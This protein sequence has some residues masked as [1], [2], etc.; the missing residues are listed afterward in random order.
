MHAARRTAGSRGRA[1]RPTPSPSPEACGRRT[2][3]RGRPPSSGSEPRRESG[4]RSRHRAPAT[5]TRARRA[6]HLALEGRGRTR[7]RLAR[8]RPASHRV[9]RAPG[10]PPLAGT[11]LGG[12]SQARGAERGSRRRRQCDAMGVRAPARRRPTTTRLDERRRA[13]ARDVATTPRV[14]RS[15]TR[16]AGPSPA[17]RRRRARQRALPAPQALAPS[18]PPTRHRS[19]PHGVET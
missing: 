10:W 16:S 5:A 3:R 11:H 4:G 7:E 13:A 1:R 15:H 9:E 12:C 19:R 14:G 18:R 2:D 8:P 17:R 6:P